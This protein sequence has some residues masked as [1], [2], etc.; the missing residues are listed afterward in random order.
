MKKRIVISFLIIM[1]PIFLMAHNPLSAVYRLDAKND[2]GI[3]KIYL[4]QAA[5][6]KSLKDIYGAD[7]INALSGK[8]FKELIVGYIK[9]NI[10]ININETRINL[11]KGGIR[12]GNH[13]TDLTFITSTIPNK[14]ENID[15]EVT[16]FKENDHHQTI[17]CFNKDNVIKEKMVLNSSNDFKNSIVYEN[18]ADYSYLMIGVSVMLFILILVTIVFKLRNKKLALLFKV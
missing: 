16:A 6:N 10:F 9:E 2:G 13:Q 15:L 11:E 3:L 4:T 12:Y 18:H 7:Y 17:F 14:I 8:E 1:S 5:L